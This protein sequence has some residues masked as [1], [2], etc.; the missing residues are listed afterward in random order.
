[1]HDHSTAAHVYLRRIESER[2]RRRLD[3]ALALA[4]ALIATL[5]ILAAHATL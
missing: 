4:I 1:M 2:R 5:L 3:T